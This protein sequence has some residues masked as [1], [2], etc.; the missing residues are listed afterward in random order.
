MA[1]FWQQFDSHERLAALKGL[2]PALY[3]ALPEARGLHK[4]HAD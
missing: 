1:D 2:R 3:E 4:L